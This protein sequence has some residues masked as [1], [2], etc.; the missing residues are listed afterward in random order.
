MSYGIDKNQRVNK[1]DDKSLPNMNEEFAGTIT[2]SSE[3]N[4]TP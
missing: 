1:E 4:A 2:A 3:H